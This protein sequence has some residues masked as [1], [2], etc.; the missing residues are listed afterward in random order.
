MGDKRQPFLRYLESM[1]GQASAPAALVRKLAQ[2]NVV[3]IAG[4]L[5][6]YR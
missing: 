2:Q 5:V 3:H 1:P 4:D 6:L